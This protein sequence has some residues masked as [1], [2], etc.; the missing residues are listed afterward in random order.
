[1]AAYEVVTIEGLKALL[2]LKNLP[3][4]IEQAAVRAINKTT[5]RTRVDAARRMQLQVNFGAGYLSP[6]AGRLRVEKQANRG[7]LEGNILGQDRPTS[8]ARFVKNPNAKKGEDLFVQV[9]PASVRRLKKAFLVKLRAGPGG[10]ET[11]RNLG[12]AIR[13]PVGQRPRRAEKG[14]AKQ[15]APGLWLLYGPSV[16]QVFNLTR[17][18]VE[19]AAL[20]FLEAEFNR[21]MEL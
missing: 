18:D 2:A 10:T 5:E 3:A 14:G 20:D 1:M 4:S 16:G 19:P 17:K 7:N 12:L 6:G 11:Q 13:L 21:L 8:L 15:I 9:A